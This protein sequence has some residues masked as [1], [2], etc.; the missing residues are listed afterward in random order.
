MAIGMLFGEN[1]FRILCFNGY[2]MEIT[3]NKNINELRVYMDFKVLAIFF[4][5]NF[6]LKKYLYNPKYY[7]N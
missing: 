3:L 4:K 6:I 2:K 1:N 5:Y 7:Y